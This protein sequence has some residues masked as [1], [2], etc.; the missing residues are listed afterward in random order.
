[1]LDLT[2]NTGE[3]NDV[4]KITELS[5]AF[6]KNIPLL[7]TCFFFLFSVSSTAQDIWSFDDNPYPIYEELT[8]EDRE[9]FY[10]RA[11]V[12]S[13]KKDCD[14]IIKR[15]YQAYQN[16][17]PEYKK[18]ANDEGNYQRWKLY[19]LISEN[20]ESCMVSTPM[21]ELVD[22]QSDLEYVHFYFCGAFS[23]P[24]KNKQEE[25]IAKR[26]T[27]LFNY[28]KTGVGV[29]VRS[30][31]YANKHTEVINLTPEAE[32]YFNKL[33]EPFPKYDNKPRDISHLITILDKEM[34]EFL[35]GLAVD[36][37]FDDL[38]ATTLPCKVR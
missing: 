23:R 11:D 24:P 28:A 30:L 19:M 15:Q 34:R 4:D 12:I 29:P 32:Y 2:K 16:H 26:I 22:P 9:Y 36:L 18:I 31:L 10:T 27:E 14:L 1:L 7:F 13:S 6:K 33:A 3:E 37:R 20:Y 25:E 35:D 8:K 38:L 21:L 5:K 17:Y